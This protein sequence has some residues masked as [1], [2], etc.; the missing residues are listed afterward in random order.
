MQI[1]ALAGIMMD[2][3]I[4]F[5]IKI[6]VD[7]FMKASKDKNTSVKVSSVIQVRPL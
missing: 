6:K 7:D 4:L 2:G 3:T 1:L 5:K